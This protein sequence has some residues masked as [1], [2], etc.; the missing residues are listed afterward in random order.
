MKT[1]KEIIDETVAEY[2]LDTRALDERGRCVYLTSGG[3]MCAVGRCCKEPKTT[4]VG[5]A[6]FIQ[7]PNDWNVIQ[8]SDILKPEY[9]GHSGDFWR[10]VQLLHDRS[11]N[12]TETGLSLLGMEY[13]KKLHDEWDEK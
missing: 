10:A 9:L 2:T 5:S 8:L 3:R 1:R 4:W 12:W 6:K 7:E 11:A 13:V